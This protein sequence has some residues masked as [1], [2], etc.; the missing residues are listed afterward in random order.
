M[1]LLDWLRYF[2]GRPRGRNWHFPPHKLAACAELEAFRRR[3]H[4]PRWV[5]EGRLTESMAAQEIAMMDYMGKCFRDA[6]DIE[7]RPPPPIIDHV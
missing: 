2:F 4:Y 6:A 3:K 5:R 1:G 7:G